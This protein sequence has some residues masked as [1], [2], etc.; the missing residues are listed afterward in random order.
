MHELNKLLGGEPHT[1]GPP[2]GCMG[3]ETEITADSPAN[4]WQ[5][6][7]DCL[8]LLAPP[9]RL[10][11]LATLV[12]MNN[13]RQNVPETVARQTGGEYAKFDNAKG[14][15]RDLFG[16]SNHLPNQYILSFH[17]RSPHPG[18]HAIGLELRNYDNLSVTARSSYW[19]DNGATSPQAP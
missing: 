5:Q 9:L 13:L 11:K 2:T 4:R 6:A 10:V 16:I 15:Q 8:S 7:Y 14:L 3:K 19:A 17:P 1:P 12:A 18:L